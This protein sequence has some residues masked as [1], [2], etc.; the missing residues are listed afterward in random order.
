[1][2][3][4]TW[5]I[6]ALLFGL[7]LFGAWDRWDALK[8]V[9]TDLRKYL[10]DMEIARDVAEAPFKAHYATHVAHIKQIIRNHFE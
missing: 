6:L 1:M 7:T 9:E 4:W 10:Q 3:F 2:D 8:D 5:V